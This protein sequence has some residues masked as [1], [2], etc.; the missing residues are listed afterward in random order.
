MDFM[1]LM[2]SGPFWNL[3][4]RME[5]WESARLTA[6]MLS[7]KAFSNFGKNFSPNNPRPLPM[8]LPF[9]GKGGGK[10]GK[11]GKG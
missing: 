1:L 6:G 9:G 2:L 3:R 4:A 5:L 7:H 11:G 10:G 8:N